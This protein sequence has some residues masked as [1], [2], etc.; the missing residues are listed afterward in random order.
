MLAEV[1]LSFSGTSTEGLDLDVPMSRRLLIEMASRAALN[2]SRVLCGTRNAEVRRPMGSSA[3]LSSFST[4]TP[5]STVVDPETQLSLAGKL[6]VSKLWVHDADAGF[7][8]LKGGRGIEGE[9]IGVDCTGT[10]IEWSWRW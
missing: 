3:S 6:H 10:P 8:S 2:L 7:H 1:V 5:L 9:F 4:Q